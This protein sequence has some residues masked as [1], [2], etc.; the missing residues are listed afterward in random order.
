MKTMQIKVTKKISGGVVAW[1]YPDGFDG[2]EI[3]L[4]AFEHQAGVKKHYNNEFA[5]GIAS[6]DFPETA[7]MVSLSQAEY[8]ATLVEIKAAQASL[9]AA[10]LAAQ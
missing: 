4:E 8:D 2:K 9:A 7:D 10:A 5:Y 6:D 1:S 3:M